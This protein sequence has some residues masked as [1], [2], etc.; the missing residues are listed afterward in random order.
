[1]ASLWIWNPPTRTS[2]MLYS[3]SASLRD[4]R[5]L[6]SCFLFVANTSTDDFEKYEFKWKGIRE[7]YPEI[8]L[9]IVPFDDN[10]KSYLA[11]I[12]SLGKEIDVIFGIFPSHM[13]GN[14][15]RVLKLG[16]SPLCC[17]VPPGH[18]LA[19]R[20]RLKVQDLYGEQLY[21]LQRGSTSHID[22][23]RDYLLQNHPKVEILDLPDYDMEVL[24]RFETTGGI[25]LTAKI[26]TDVHPS[27]ATVPVDWE[28]S[29]PYGLL[30][31]NHPTK[32]VEQFVEAVKGTAI[33]C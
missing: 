6:T 33:P 13:H 5:T 30:Y 3:R 25:L 4:S 7:Q 19:R 23:L 9:Q 27:L 11:T 28:F 12:A 26:W 18:P 32:P 20:S 21:L 17:G 24:H 14:L 15:C 22:A 29:V 2:S 1:M 31:S 8:R 16:C 10:R